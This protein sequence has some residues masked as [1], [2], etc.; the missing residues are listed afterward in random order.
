M[1]PT[2][3][4]IDTDPG[5][6]DLIALALALRSPE[7]RLV[8]VTTTYGNATLQHTTRN[9]RDLLMHVGRRDLPL[10]PGAAHP[11][12]RPLT[13]APETHGASGIGYATASEAVPVHPDPYA[14]LRALESS[15]TPVVLLTLGP[16]TNLALALEADLGRVRVG[17]RR[18]LGL[19]G[20]LHERGNTSR[21]A[22]FNA[23]SDPEAVERVLRAD[24]GTV[25]IGLDVTRRMTCSA[26]EVDVFCSDGDVL[27]RWLGYAL[28]FYVE[29]HRVQR[30][31]DGCVLNDVLPIGETVAPG[32]LTL[33]ER[34]IRVNLDEGDERGRTV[35]HSDGVSLHAALGVDVPRMRALL[36]RVFVLPPRP[37]GIHHGRTR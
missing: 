5:I 32:L 23:W 26:T 16:L 2:P 7:L 18:H 36:S 20:S 34:R 14:L 9:A 1:R 24:L 15:R 11:L 8:A 37:G 10:F 3:V 21:W 30:Q 12:E 35:E 19:F 13:T 29:S 31:F 33:A 4:I 28:R 25:M 6:D 27:T 17:V 22:D